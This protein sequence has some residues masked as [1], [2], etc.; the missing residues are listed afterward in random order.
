MNVSLKTGFVCLCL[1]AGLS[2]C[3]TK[4]DCDKEHDPGITVVYK[5]FV[6]GAWEPVHVYALDKDNG[7]RVDSINFTS[8]FQG[9]IHVN[10]GLFGEL[11]PGDFKDYDY[12]ITVGTTAKDTIRDVAYQS[13]RYDVECNKC[14]LAD[15]SATVQDYKDFQFRY[16]G[17]LYQDADTLVIER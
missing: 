8:Y 12:V 3:C 6:W 9:T 16:A 5:N 10:E 11:H 2:A 15:G 17:R 7:T 14:L 13:Y 4:M 1:L